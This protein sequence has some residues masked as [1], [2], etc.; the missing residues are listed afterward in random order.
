MTRILAVANQ[1]GGVGKTTTA[2]NLAA[3]LAELH[4][5]V[6]LL[7]LD[8]QANATSGLGFE[9]IPGASLYDVL[10]G[11]TRLA[12]KIRPTAV[13]RLDL[14]PSE[15][16]LCGV[17]I[18]VARLD[19]PLYRLRDALAPV[20]ADNRYH[21]ILADCPPSLGLLTM[22]ALAAADGLFIPLQ[23]E[24]YALEGLSI[25]NRVLNDIRAN[26]INP[27][28]EIAGIVMTMYDSRTN[29]AQ[30]VV[31]EVRQHFGDR[32]LQTVVPRTVRLSEA[33]GFG[34]PI[35]LFDPHG[36]GAQSY[37]AVA[38]ELLK[39][40]RLRQMPP[41]AAVSESDAPPP[42]A[43]RTTPE[44]PSEPSAGEALAAASSAAPS[45]NDQSVAP[46]PGD[47]SHAEPRGPPIPEDGP[48]ARGH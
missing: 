29:L 20:A 36:L 12:D 38:R 41:A 30:Q 21:F 10:L 18:E 11:E 35:I 8:P 7:D 31:K 26:G 24:Y 13:P 44:R 16:D 34:Q 47:P 33:P 46:P 22:N 5:R 32:V 19:R 40:E 9:R 39:R 1:K 27:A 3:C 17:E 14:V 43:E 15:T 23:C 28:L 42:P 4:K 2:I 48:P 45:K 6:L 37:R 25:L